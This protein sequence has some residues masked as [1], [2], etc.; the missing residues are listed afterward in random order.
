[1]KLITVFLLAAFAD[2][3][4][5]GAPQ[6]EVS[7]ISGTTH[8]GTLQA[9]DAQN[10]TLVV[11]DKPT[12]L[13]AAT[14]LEARLAGDPLKLVTK[15]PHE[16]TLLDGTRLSAAQVAIKGDSVTVT[17]P[18]AG[19]LGLPRKSLSSIRLAESPSTVDDAWLALQKRERRQDM[20]IVQK[21]ETLDFVEGVIGNITAEAV[22]L[23]LDGEGVD[24]PRE[25]VFGIVFYN[26]DGAS[27]K[28]E[29]MVELTNGDRLTV[30]G[31]KAAAE[32]LTL[33]LTSGSDVSIP[34]SAVRTIDYSFG[35]LTWLSSLEP[36]DLKREFRFIEPAEAL[37]N[38]R[39]LSGKPL[40]LG[41][42]VF[43]RGVSVRSK[44]QLRYRLNGDYTR[45][46][47]WAGIQQGFSGDVRLTIS[48]DGTK[49]F[50]ELIKPTDEAPRRIDLE[51][52][53]RFNLEILVDYGSAESDIG[54][55]LTLGDARLLR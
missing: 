30:T 33:T 25:K 10:W 8:T 17:S 52:S 51:T 36:R 35:K 23:L 13:P 12:L 32:S 7:T 6:V 31:L 54:D 39:D 20:L 5:V 55:H 15:P 2:A 28:A 53:G 16:V 19:E 24:V 3:P 40:R 22:T 29:G 47:C 45:F 37:R 14:V 11:D 26:R 46:Q 9:I 49:A 44:S 50:D 42:R 4:Q 38:D 41:D 18:T 27:A 43:S 21:G 1:M 34:V 48:V